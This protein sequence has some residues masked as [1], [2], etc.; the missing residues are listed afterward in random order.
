MA[1][2][3]ERMSK[4]AAVVDYEAV[5]TDLPEGT[6]GEKKQETSV[7]ISGVSVKIRIWHLKQK[8]ITSVTD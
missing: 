1:N 2:G 4:E 6:E 5:P 3:F 7:M 8:H